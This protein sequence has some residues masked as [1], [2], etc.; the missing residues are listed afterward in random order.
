[1]LQCLN[2]QPLVKWPSLIQVLSAKL[3]FAKNEF[4]VQ[5]TAIDFTEFSTAMIVNVSDILKC[6]FFALF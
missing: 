3:T 2:K 5:K 1:M 4:S 6:N